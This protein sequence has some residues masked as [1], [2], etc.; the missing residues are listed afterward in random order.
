MWFKKKKKA[1]AIKTIGVLD[2]L[3][4]LPLTYKYENVDVAGVKFANPDFSIIEVADSV[5]L[6]EEPENIKDKNAIRV[7]CKNQKIGYLHKNNLQKMVA[8]W[9][10]C[11]DPILAYISKIDKENNKIELFMEFYGGPAYEKEKEKAEQL[12]EEEL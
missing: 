7:S 6:D 10:K 2:E 4:G 5:S 11:K 3:C 9:H 1:P 8:D 12:E